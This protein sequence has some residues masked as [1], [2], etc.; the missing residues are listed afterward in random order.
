MN[1]IT[2]EQFKELVGLTDYQQLLDFKDILD[3]EII[4]EET[5]ISEGFISPEGEEPEYCNNP[6]CLVQGCTENH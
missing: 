5:G 2:N 1:A 4:F 6:S 3:K